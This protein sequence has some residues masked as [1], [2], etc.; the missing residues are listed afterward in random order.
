VLLPRRGKVRVDNCPV[1]ANTLV[2]VR[3][4]AGLVFQDPNDQLFMPT[5]AEDVAFGPVNQRLS[6]AQVQRRVSEVLALEPDI[7][8]LD[9]PSASLDPASRR[10][11]IDG[12]AGLQFAS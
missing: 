11:L 2:E 5:V 7:L 3:R 9:E 12:R 1:T 4:H 8:L 6:E 10:R